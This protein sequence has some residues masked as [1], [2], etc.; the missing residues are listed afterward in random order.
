MMDDIWN[1]LDRFLES[2]TFNLFLER[3][4]SQVPD[5]D[6]WTIRER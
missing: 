1:N 2:E 4:R 6:K 3:V 5:E